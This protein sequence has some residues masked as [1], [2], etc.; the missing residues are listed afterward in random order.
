MLKIENLTVKTKDKEI[1]KNFNIDIGFGEVH[2]IM[3]PNGTGKSTLSKVIMG[4]SDYEILNGNIIFCG[5]NLN[6]LTPDERAR[7]G[8]F[9]SFQNPLSI[10]GVTNS[11][12]LR[13]AIN[14]NRENPI[15]LYEFIKELDKSVEELSMPNDMIHR[16]VN[17][18][19]SGGERK[20]NEIL[21]M[22]LL[23]PKF[24]ILDELDSGLD[25]DSLK[26]VCQNI[27]NYLKENKDTSVLIIT[28]YPRILEYIRPKY[29]HILRDGN[30]VS[31]GD[32]N[33]ALQ[34]EKDGYSK[35]NNLNGNIDNE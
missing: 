33:L 12:F 31:K 23:K 32:Y 26:T 15:G 2:A 21:Q 14:N 30:I 13:T 19:A 27:N 34:V 3:G 18:G 28:H 1:L 20:K 4:S 6:G 24:L 5:D 17:K 16:S 25:V 8:I 7:K 9:L 22:K 11:E 10:E 35:I 29:V